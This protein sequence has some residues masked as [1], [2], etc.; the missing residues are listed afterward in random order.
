MTRLEAINQIEL[1][2]KNTSD[3]PNYVSGLSHALEIFESIDDPPDLRIELKSGEIPPG[4]LLLLYPDGIFTVTFNRMREID[5]ETLSEARAKGCKIYSLT[6]YFTRYFTTIKGVNPI[7]R[8]EV[9]LEVTRFRTPAGNPTCALKVTKPEERCVFL[10]SQRYGTEYTCLFE[11]P[12]YRGVNIPL[13]SIENGNY[14][15]PCR[16][17]LVWEKRVGGE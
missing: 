4:W 6:L 8:E 7:T 12:S 3:N 15:K 16:A 10:A 13:E 1:M 14:L 11:D 2:I 17:C 5:L 9:K